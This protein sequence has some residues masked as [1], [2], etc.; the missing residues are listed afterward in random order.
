MKPEE[1]GPGP[2]AKYSTK[3]LQKL[4]EDSLPVENG[5][6]SELNHALHHIAYTTGIMTHYLIALE[7]GEEEDSIEMRANLDQIRRYEMPVLFEYLLFMA[8]VLHIDLGGL[9][10]EHAVMMARDREREKR[11]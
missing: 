7:H 3:E 1:F 2:L 9:Y 8:N 5:V 10:F 4:V 11:K 6:E